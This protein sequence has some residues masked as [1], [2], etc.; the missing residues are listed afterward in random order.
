[1]RRSA[2]QVSASSM[3]GGAGST[4]SSTR[5]TGAEG[6]PQTSPTASQ[7]RAQEGS[8]IRSSTDTTSANDGGEGSLVTFGTLPGTGSLC[9]T[10]YG[11]LKTSDE[12]NLRLLIRASTRKPGQERLRTGR[13]LTAS[14]EFS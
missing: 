13:S 4:A 9:R 14:V 10:T 11:V 12:T 2:R 8:Y 1:M 3:T 6:S 5:R 7:S